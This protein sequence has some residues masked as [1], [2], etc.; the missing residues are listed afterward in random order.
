VAAGPEAAAEVAAAAPGD[1]A[2][3][4]D[5]FSFA[6][7][8]GHFLPLVPAARAA[9][10]VVAFAGQAGMASTVEL[11]VNVVVTVAAPRC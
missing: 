7:A 5:P 9:G 2:P 6:G 3:Q 1:H 10:H 11:A 4:R 8:T